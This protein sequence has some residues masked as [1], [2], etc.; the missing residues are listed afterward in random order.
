[1]PI[2]ATDSITLAFEH[3]KRQLF[4]PF[5][6]GQWVRL[7]FVGLLAGELGS[8][9]NL[10]PSS[11]GTQPAAIPQLGEIYHKIDP[12]ILASVIT[13]LV[14]TGI[15]LMVV[16][17][18]ISSVMRFILFDS[19]LTRECHLRAGWGRRQ[20]NGWK[21]FVWQLGLLLATFAGALVLVGGPAAFAFGM[22][23]FQPPRAHLVQL[24]LTGV[25]VFILFVGFVI[26]LALVHVLTKDFIVPQMAFEGINAL[27]AWRRL[28]P[29]IQAETKGYAAYIAMKIVLTIV[30]GIAIGIVT[31]ILGLI[32]AIPVIGAV[33]AAVIAGKTA[34][35]TW[36]LLTITAAVAA[37]CILFVI[38]FFLVSLI[39]VP[40]IVFFP[41]YS[42]YFFAAR[43][44]PLSLA[45][46]SS[47]PQS[48]VPQGA[49][50]PLTPPPYPA[51]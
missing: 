48:A 27:E 18:Y 43:Y 16:M 2:S 47:A 51:M 46:Y 31:L 5:R 13:V 30:V 8:G 19:V 32:L 23:W 9:G 37:A 38:F 39:S 41:A 50:P 28:W 1:V 10:N 22:G 6:F 14:I 44:Q 49:P 29:M 45:L 33:A 35:L 40:A 12:A 21:Y 3:T 20:E 7:A 25:V 4:K 34:G 26:G 36:N 42:I 24:V 17:A 15:V 11:H